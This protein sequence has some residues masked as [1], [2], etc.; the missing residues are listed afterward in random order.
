MRISARLA[1]VVM[2]LT[3]LGLCLAGCAKK[4]KK[5]HVI[6]K[7]YKFILRQDSDHSFVVDAEG[8]VKNVG[9]VDVKNVVV[10]GYCRSCGQILANG[11][12]FISDYAKTPDQKD[13]I[14]YLPKG[15]DAKFKFKGVA[16]MMDQSGKKPASLP[17]KMDIVIES[18]ETV[19]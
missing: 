6:V 15:A 14:S 2:A 5:G 11:Q 17:K 16:F 9:E 13:V 18:F 3:L 10:T 8:T 19:Q 12:W 4:E 7:D 1:V